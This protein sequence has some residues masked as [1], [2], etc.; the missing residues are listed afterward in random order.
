M[1][2]HYGPSPSSYPSATSIWCP[3]CELYHH[4]EGACAVPLNPRIAEHQDWMETNSRF[5]HACP[6]LD[7]ELPEGLAPDDMEPIDPPDELFDCSIYNEP[8]DMINH[9]PHYNQCG[10]EAI[11][12]IEAYAGGNYH[13][14]AALKYLLRADYKG[15]KLEDLRKAIWYIEREIYRL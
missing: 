14:G 13:R 4:P 6:D 9:P 15:S 1:P 10:I 3:Y 11:D 8:P 7:Q 5:A 12:V 2:T